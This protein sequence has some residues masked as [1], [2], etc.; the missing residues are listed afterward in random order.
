[1]LQLTDGCTTYSECLL[2]SKQQQMF[3]QLSYAIA[4]AE[5]TLGTMKMQYMQQAT[6]KLICNNSSCYLCIWLF[7]L[8]MDLHT[9]KASHCNNIICSPTQIQ[10]HAV[11]LM[12][13][14]HV[15]SSTNLTQCSTKS[16]STLVP[17][18][19]EC[20]KLSRNVIAFAPCSFLPP[21][22]GYHC[23]LELTSSNAR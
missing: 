15:S 13:K 19:Q 6:C 12:Y 16:L 7:I 3:V 4:I 9:E 18:M 10:L 21:V 23:K 17:C 14:N 20:S 5:Y 2:N 22:P 11:K 8:A 1:M